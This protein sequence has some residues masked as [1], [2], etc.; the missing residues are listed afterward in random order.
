MNI[1][2]SNGLVE[3]EL[4]V[5]DW[6]PNLNLQAFG[7]PLE[8]KPLEQDLVLRR[9]DK[10]GNRLPSVKAWDA[11][12]IRKPMEE[13]KFQ[14]LSDGFE[15]CTRA[16]LH[17][18]YELLHGA[19]DNF[20]AVR[21]RVDRLAEL[22][23]QQAAQRNSEIDQQQKRLQ[24]ELEEALKALESKHRD[25]TSQLELAHQEA[26][27]RVAAAGACYNPTRLQ[28]EMV[29][30]TPLV[31]RE[32]LLDREQLTDPGVEAQAK[33]PGWLTYAA[34][35]LVGS[36]IGISLGLLMG[37]INPATMGRRW[38]TTLLFCLVGLA[39]AL[40]M[41]AAL[42]LAFLVVGENDHLKVSSGRIALS[43]LSALGLGLAFAA[44]DCM[45][46]YHGLLKLARLDAG[47]SALS[48]GAAQSGHGWAYF[49]VAAIV[50]L[51][52][53]AYSAYEGWFLGRSRVIENRAQRGLLEARE[54]HQE[55]RLNQPEARPALEAV[56]VVR[57]LEHRQKQLEQSREDLQ[58][59][60]Q[61][62]LAELESRRV[63]LS[64][65]PSLTLRYEVQD[66]HDNLLG[67]QM[68][69]DRLIDQL[70]GL[71]LPWWARLLN[72]F[73]RK[74]TWGKAG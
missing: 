37:A 72:L 44:V 61:K 6:T 74:Y 39:P 18:R 53:L 31:S 1:K 7:K 3:H 50:T 32:M 35:S 13:S 71:R 2:E 27:L 41:R 15:P 70:C 16:Y 55:Q 26:A 8:S 73:S 36:L 12:H 67:A 58:A 63:A 19:Y 65:L 34:T 69:L 60:Y 68:E 66:A 5:G 47:L 24:L 9:R 20:C 11:P 51:G 49:C 43:R 45:V 42:K 52:Y 33:L 40:F 10:Y 59:C 64:S 25:F 14:R 23:L 28:T 21:Q 4:K 57:H 48:G 17:Y 56:S 22:E 62:Q 46:E 29:L 30:G 54:A 38:L